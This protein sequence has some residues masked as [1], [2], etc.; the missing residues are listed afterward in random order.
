VNDFEAMAGEHAIKRVALRFGSNAHYR[1]DD[2]DVQ[3]VRVVGQ[4]SY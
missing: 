4:K 3:K 1:A 2:G